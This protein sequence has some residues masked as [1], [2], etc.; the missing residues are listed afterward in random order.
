MCGVVIGNYS[1]R[2]RLT[3]GGGNYTTMYTDGTSVTLGNITAN[4]A[5]DV[6]VAAI[7]SQ[8]GQFTE[9]L[10]FELQGMLCMFCAIVHTV[11]T[12]SVI[13]SYTLSTGIIYLCN[14][15]FIISLQSPN[16]RLM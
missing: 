12:Y 11:R 8:I 2:Y 13:E 15:I 3:I 5:Y 4:A 16:L 1:V 10:Q 6:S 14:Y 7:S 9:P